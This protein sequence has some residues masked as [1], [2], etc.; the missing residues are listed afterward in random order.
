[1]CYNFNSK[2]VDLKKAMKDFDA[3]E[4]DTSNFSM[5][6]INAFA[7][8][9]KP[10]IPAIVNH[11]GLVLMP[12]YWGIKEIKKYPTSGLNLTSEKTYRDYKNIQK[13]RCLIPA[14]SYY[15]GKKVILPTNKAG[16]QKHEMFWKDRTQFYIAAFYD[17]WS[18]GNIGFGLVTTEPNEVQAAIHDRMIITL[19]EKMGKEFLDQKPIEKFQFPNFSPNLDFINLEPEKT[20]QTLF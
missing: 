6:I 17:F 19:D 16:S 4:V 1:M 20:Q 10:T 12:T 15:E 8:Q 14:T 3:E 7:K 11:N 9:M 2:G 18:D 5:G 13:N